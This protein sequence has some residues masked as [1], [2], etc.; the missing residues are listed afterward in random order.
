MQSDFGPDFFIVGAPKCGTTWLDTRLSE[1]PSI[2]M[3]K[4]EQHYFGSDLATNWV[5]PTAEQYFASFAGGEQAARRGEASGW[6]LWSKAAAEE[7]KRYKPNAQIIAM[8]RN[9][10]EMLPSLHSQYLYDD[11]ED[12]DDFEAALAAEEAR[13]A[14]LKV[15][16]N[17]GSPPWRLFYRDVVRF[18]AQVRRYFAAF[19]R[20][21]V[22]VVLFDDL[23]ANASDVFRGVLDFLGVDT[24]VSPCLQTL[25]A[26]KQIR[27]RHVQHAVMEIL[28]PSSRIRR[29]GA[30][31]IPGQAT[32]S[33]LLRHVVPAM[34]RMNTS[35]AVRTPLPDE[36]RAR[37]TIEFAPESE[38]LGELIERDLSSWYSD[39]RLRS[40]FHRVLPVS[41]PQ[42][43]I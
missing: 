7:I 15:P 18:H 5:Q 33:A 27:S 25:N 9:P 6:Y 42:M 40:E 43:T 10:V 4:K 19:G 26:N 35:H 30:R 21:R 3:A 39:A 36:L 12:T 28:N 13:R 29:C 41:Q 8:L 24:N 23:V 31:L 38:A 34:V 16:P 32:R 17:N 20:Q 14:G 11:I 2:F 1:H 22:H 37:L